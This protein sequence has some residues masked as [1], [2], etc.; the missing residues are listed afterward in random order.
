MTYLWNHSNPWWDLFSFVMVYTKKHH[1]VFSLRKSFRAQETSVT[2][3]R[4]KTLESSKQIH[5]NL[6]GRFQTLWKYQNRTQ[7]IIRLS[8]K[9]SLVS[10]KNSN[11]KRGYCL[12]STR[13]LYHHVPTIS[14]YLYIYI[15]NDG[16]F[17]GHMGDCVFFGGGWI[18][19]LLSSPWI[20]IGMRFTPPSKVKNLEAKNVIILGGA[21]SL[22]CAL[23]R[24]PPL[25][26]HDGKTNLRCWQVCQRATR[27]M[28]WVN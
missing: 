13:N 8:T 1:H 16:F 28:F 2:S 27:N 7:T 12:V 18:K 5:W 22:N 21:A 26:E 23:D 15:Y 6:L 19:M 17:G 9:K 10:I 25:W 24:C 3:P 4:R 14:L 11:G 20:C